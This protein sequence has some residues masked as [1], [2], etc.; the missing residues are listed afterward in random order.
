VT[1]GDVDDVAHAI[2]TRPQDEIVFANGPMRL[3]SFTPKLTVFN[4][5]RAIMWLKTI[6]AWSCGRRCLGNWLLFGSLLITNTAVA[7]KLAAAYDK[8]P[9]FTIPV[10]FC[11]L[12]LISICNAIYGDRGEGQFYLMRTH[13]L[14]SSSYLLGTGLYAF[15]VA[16]AYTT[17]MLSLQYATPMYRDP[18]L[19]S[20]TYDTGNNCEVDFGDNPIA[21]PQDIPISDVYNGQQVQLQAYSVPSGF[22]KVFAAGLV[23]AITFPGA[24]FASSYFPGNKFAL[25][26]VA[27]LSLAA[28]ITPL[29]LYFVSPVRQSDEKLSDC[30]E[31]LGYEACQL[32]F[33]MSTMNET[34]INCVGLF[35]QD[36]NLQTL[37]TPTYAGLLPQFGFF[38]SLSLSFIS[39]VK[40][41]SDPPEYVENVLLPQLQGVR[42]SGNTCEVPLFATKLYGQTIAF[43]I[44]GA[45]ILTLVGVMLAILFTFPTPTVL[46]AKLMTEHAIKKAR[47]RLTSELRDSASSSKQEPEFSEVVEERDY[48]DEIVRPLLATTATDSLKSQDQ[49]GPKLENAAIPREAIPPILMHRL[50]KVYPSLG[51]L[52]PKVALHSLDLHVPKGQVLG[53]LGQN[54]SGKTTTLKILSCAHDA[55]SGIGLVT[56]HDVSCDRISIFERLGNCPQFDVIWPKL[57]VKEHLLFFAKLKGIPR[58]KILSASHEIASIVGLGTDQVYNRQAGALSGGMRRRLSIAMALIGAPSVFLLDEPCTGTS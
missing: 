43:E 24:T 8:T 15:F 40:F 36:S 31:R 14:L 44:C 18:T 23:F 4:Q 51:G 32:T 38:Q 54:G 9:A 45:V 34:F 3:A 49:D 19:C 56:G 47:C 28:S 17:I 37:C 13:S 20:D 26:A 53:L 50:R 46:H 52:P 1:H 29:V 35:L 2:P 22:G 48:V 25:V 39:N 5:V 57:T 42:C 11:S 55:T 27:F 30:F 58:D 6:R 12:I 41:I 33:D 16:F 7:T 10:T 21:Q